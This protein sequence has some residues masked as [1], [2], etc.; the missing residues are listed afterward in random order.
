MIYLKYPTPIYNIMCVGM[1]LN[2]S[3][4]NGV[5]IEAHNS[6]GNGSSFGVEIIRDPNDGIVNL[7]FVCLVLVI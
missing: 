7:R 5:K 4:E 2:P 1:S 3:S 6:E